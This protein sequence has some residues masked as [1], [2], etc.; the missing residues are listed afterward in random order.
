M[1]SPNK[2]HQS[3]E[4]EVSVTMKRTYLM[5]AVLCVTGVLGINALAQTLDQ[6]S[7]VKLRSERDTTDSNTTKTLNTKDDPTVPNE[8]E[9]LKRR[10]EDL[11]KQN[12]SMLEMLTGVRSQLEAMN[13]PGPNSGSTLSASASQPKPTVEPTSPPKQGDA[14]SKN[15][16]VRWGELISEGNKIK[17]YGF[18]RLDLLVDSQRPN[19]AQSI[20]FITSPDP[21]IGT[22]NGNFTMHPR[23]TRLG[24]DWSGPQIAKLG[25][26]KL[27]G[28]LETDFQNG[29]TESRQIIRIRHAYLRLDWKKFSILGG[30]TWDV[31]SPLFPTVNS[32]TLQWNAGNVGDRRP[33]LRL[34]YE[35]RMGRGKFSLAGAIALTGAI[36][37]LDLDANGVRD[38]EESAR[39]Q[40]QGR[41]GYSRPLGSKDRIM[42]FGISGQYGY[43]RTA[44]AI[45]GRTDF[46]SQLVN[47]DFTLPLTSRLAVK[48]EGWWGRNMSDLR[49]GAGQGINVT[50]A[51]EIRGRGGWGEINVKVSRYLSVNPGF[52]MDDPVNEDIPLGGRTDNRAFFIATR[53]TPWGNFVIGVDYLRWRTSFKGFL[54]GN[55][56]RVNTFLQYNF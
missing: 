29:G 3:T 11:E 1:Y 20:L 44:R 13:H 38:G 33:Q 40:I 35:P 4:S 24:I 18:L 8:I 42:S 47:I 43:L 16:P 21:R 2:F 54:R 31:V 55:D 53:I 25:N 37:A 19:N 36:D 45:V 9:A 49:G 51:R 5:I 48:A 30:Q 23:L 41:V 26:A 28:K 14:G 46:R 32:D 50:T 56:N 52:S 34:T 22:G 17:L 7:T 10:I 6:N 39:P 15:E 12:R 27:T